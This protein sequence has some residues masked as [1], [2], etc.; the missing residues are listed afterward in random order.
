MPETR[1][2]DPTGDDPIQ[3]AVRKALG[4][5]I[6]PTEPGARPTPPVPPSAPAA[7]A[8]PQSI[9]TSFATASIP[10]PRPAEND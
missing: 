1:T 9:L 7:A 8:L 5:T 3:N 6:R 2:F 10:T 4:E